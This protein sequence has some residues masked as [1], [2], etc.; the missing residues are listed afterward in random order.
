M[1]V[2]LNQRVLYNSFIGLNIAANHSLNVEPSSF[3]SLA[4][5]LTADKRLG[6]YLRAYRAIERSTSP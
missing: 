1:I 4:E 3:S 2:V 6:L 5:K